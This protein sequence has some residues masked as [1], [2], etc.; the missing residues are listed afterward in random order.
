MLRKSGIALVV[1]VTMAMTATV[2]LGASV[3]FKGGN[4]TFTD[5]GLTLTATGG[6]AGLGNQDVQVVLTATGTPS[7]TCT[8]Q[9]GNQAP[10]QNPAEV[11]LTGVQNIPATQI[12]NGNVTFNVTTGAPAQPTAAEA[13]CPNANW[14]AQITDVEFTSATISVKQGGVTVFS[15]SFTL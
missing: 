14:T 15:R 2:A 1:A 11:T 6:L 7:A 9:G 13:G 4:P 8:N 5:N 3:H 10:G 12:K